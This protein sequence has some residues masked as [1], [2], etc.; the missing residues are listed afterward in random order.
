MA[1]GE[2]LGAKFTLDITNLKAGLSDA[3]RLIRQSESEFITA[4]AGMN[5]WS[6]SLD[7]LTARFDS[8]NKQTDI[9]KQKIAALTKVREDTIA[10]MKDEGAT[11]EEI[12]K[13]IDKVN[14]Q[15]IKEQKQ[16][17]TLQDRT[18]KAAA[19]LQ[20]FY[21]AENDA[22]EGADELGK[23]TTDAGEAAEKSPA[24]R[25]SSSD[26]LSRLSEVLWSYKRRTRPL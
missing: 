13:A 1:S 8:L 11:D 24:G 2:N 15:I 12:E 22:G 21:E 7:G 9:Q 3:N 5:D 25:H 26:R 20:S 4:A 14:V 17:Q 18:D 6:K 19:E 23:A 10:K 16:L